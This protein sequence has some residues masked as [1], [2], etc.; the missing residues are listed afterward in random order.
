LGFVVI[1]GA[2]W[3]WLQAAHVVDLPL[4]EMFSDAAVWT[5]MTQTDFG[6]VW[7]A[8]L[9]LVGLLTA[10]LLPLYCTQPIKPRW[11]RLVAVV[12]AAGLVGTLAWAGHAAA[13]R[14]SSRGAAHLTADILHLIAAAAWVGALGPLAVL[15]G[16]TGQGGDEASLSIAREAALRFSTLGIASVSALL[17]TGVVNSWMLVGSV[18][19]LVGTD[20]GRLLSLKIALFVVMVTIAGDQSAPADPQVTGTER[21]CTT[22]T[23]SASK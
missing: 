1:S 14:L 5:V 20:Y 10:A 9:A 21:Y 8:R 11:R 18:E 4:S 3:L 15:L 19:A 16:Q 12:L 22:S 13:T 7:I 6:H 23:A 17:A 2:A